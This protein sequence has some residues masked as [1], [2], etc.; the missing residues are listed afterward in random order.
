M[1]LEEARRRCLPELQKQLDAYIRTAESYVAEWV[2]KGYLSGRYPLPLYAAEYVAEHFRDCGLSAEVEKTRSD[3]AELHIIWLKPEDVAPYVRGQRQAQAVEEVEAP[4]PRFTVEVVVH[5]WHQNA[6]PERR[7]LW[8]YA[9][10]EAEVTAEEAFQSQIPGLLAEAERYWGRVTLSLHKDGLEVKAWIQSPDC[11]HRRILRPSQL[12]AAVPAGP[13]TVYAMAH[14]RAGG[15]V[16]K[17]GEE[18]FN[19]PD[20]YVRAEARWQYLATHLEELRS[21]DGD[22]LAVVM[23]VQGDEYR[24]LRQAPPRSQARPAATP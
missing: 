2:D 21:L 22:T 18:V 5:P 16:L 17:T 4:T 24:V 1:N 12:D 11:G 6:L 9:G 10:P 19:G 13:I 15:K 8:Q 23:R 20:A 7:V 14:D 3:D